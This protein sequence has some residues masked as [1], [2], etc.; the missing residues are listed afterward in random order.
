MTF[1]VLGPV[2]KHLCLA[3]PTPRPFGGVRAGKTGWSLRNLG[4]LHCL[5]DHLLH[6][7]LAYPSCCRCLRLART[8]CIA[9]GT[10]PGKSSTTN[11]ATASRTSCLFSH[12]IFGTMTYRCRACP[13]ALPPVVILHPS[14]VSLRV[15]RPNNQVCIHSSS[16][17]QPCRFSA[18]LFEAQA[19][20]CSNIN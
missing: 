12:G 14:K 11:S 3:V 8:D 10:L 9:G 18:W 19:R 16:R 2:K 13:P 5:T 4:Y 20:A 1:I 17:R 15:P 6:S 7:A